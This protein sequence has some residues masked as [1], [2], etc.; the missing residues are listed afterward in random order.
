[1]GGE[2]QHICD[3]ILRATNPQLLSLSMAKTVGGKVEVEEVV[4]VEASLE[5]AQ[6]ENKSQDHFTFKKMFK[7]VK[8]GLAFR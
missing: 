8:N 7:Y 1:M 6:S 4:A 2:G 5:S 3:N